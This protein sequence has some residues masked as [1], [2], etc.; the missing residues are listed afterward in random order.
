MR[1]GLVEVNVLEDLDPGEEENHC[2]KVYVDTLVVGDYLRERVLQF[3][4]IL[5]SK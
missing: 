4:Y 5:K 1:H 3:D 2:S